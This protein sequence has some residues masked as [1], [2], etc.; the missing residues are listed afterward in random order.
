MKHVLSIFLLVLISYAAQ[1]QYSGGGEDNPELL[2]NKESLK[3]FQDMR[4]GM[5]IHWGPVELKG[6][7]ISWSGGRE[8]S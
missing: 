7:V 4:F 3:K 6:R 2:T 5:F 1:A 8:I